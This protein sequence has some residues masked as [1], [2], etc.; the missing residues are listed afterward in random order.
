MFICKRCLNDQKHWD[1]H[2]YYSRGPCEI[3]HKV[4]DTVDCHCYLARKAP[5]SVEPIVSLEELT[6]QYKAARSIRDNGVT[7]RRV[8]Q[9]IKK[10]AT[11]KQQ[12]D[13]LESTWM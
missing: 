3:C 6:K 9:K 8:W 1:H 13:I 12:V 5:K 2:L 10:I 7:L 11:L 4:S